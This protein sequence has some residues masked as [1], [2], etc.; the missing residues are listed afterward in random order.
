MVL[1]DNGNEAKKTNKNN[2]KQAM[3]NQK[4]TTNSHRGEKYNIKQL[5]CELSEM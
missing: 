2:N 1:M 4:L 5:K 3:W